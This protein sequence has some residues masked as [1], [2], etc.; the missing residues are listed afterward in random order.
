MSKT[1]TE[2][3]FQPDRPG[4]LF[5]PVGHEP[6][7]ETRIGSQVECKACATAVPSTQVFMERHADKQQRLSDGSMGTCAEFWGVAQGGG[8]DG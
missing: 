3:R 4:D 1:I 7:D 8:A 6:F 2:K 5:E